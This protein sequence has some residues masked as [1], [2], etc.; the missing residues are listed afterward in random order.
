M[1]LPGS[2]D[3][4]RVES[5]F[6]LGDSYE[7]EEKSQLKGV[8]KMSL[9]LSEDPSRPATAKLD[10]WKLEFRSGRECG[11]VFTDP[12]LIENYLSYYKT[13]SDEVHC[14]ACKFGRRNKIGSVIAAGPQKRKKK[15]KEEESSEEESEEEGERTETW[16]KGEKKFLVVDYTLVGELPKNYRNDMAKFCARSNLDVMA[17]EFF[18]EL[19][20]D[21]V[22]E[23]HMA[24][25][26][27]DGTKE[28]VGFAVYTPNYGRRLDHFKINTAT[29]LSER[30]WIPQ[31]GDRDGW[32][33]FLVEELREIKRQGIGNHPEAS[34]AWDAQEQKMQETMSTL[35]GFLM[36]TDAVYQVLEEI[37]T[38]L[39]VFDSTKIEGP[40]TK[41]P[42]EIIIHLELICVNAIWGTYGVSKGLFRYLENE[43]IIFAEDNQG[44][45]T[46]AIV[47]L[48]AA[49]PQVKAV[50]KYYGL[51]ELE[52]GDMVM[53]S[54]NLLREENRLN[55]QEVFKRRVQPKR[56]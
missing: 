36:E 13:A 54:D 6:V 5:S 50:Y 19:E 3:W 23:R 20:G 27:T 33:G 28:I 39:Y 12:Y 43:L 21:N 38:W 14:P 51:H 46:S 34:E 16:T 56:R 9:S 41:N 30:G 44:D 52:E 2:S 7:E 31:D 11:H 29:F 42:E 15:E 8:T 53:E 26:R 32:V 18:D 49:N 24:I 37:V 4:A 48:T 47:S 22:E 25:A 17:R 10:L 1:T 45:V 55:V 40:T 35:K